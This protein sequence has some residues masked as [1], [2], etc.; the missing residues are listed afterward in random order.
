MYREF[1]RIGRDLFLAGLITSHG[2]N[3]SVRLG[4]RLFITRRG[5]M[6]GRLKRGD[7]IETGLEEDDSGIA[8][9]SS[10]VVVHRAIYRETAALAVLHAHPPYT[11]VLSLSRDA[12]VPLDSEASYLLHR[13]P[14]L[15]AEKTIGS[16]EVAGL[17]A[18]ALRDYKI[19]V[20]R[21]HGTFATGQ[22]LEEAWQW[23]SC[24]EAASMIVYLAELSG[25]KIKEYRRGTA[26]Y[27]HW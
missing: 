11:V 26:D 10:E 1:R 23:T 18:P 5:A 21:G 3:L 14:V 12:I 20:L 7:V 13:V 22:F 27:A 17:V 2:G 15:A 4:D 24:L 16:A 9:A 25:E 6:L 8:L 19:V